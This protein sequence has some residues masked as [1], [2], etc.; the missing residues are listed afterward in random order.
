MYQND[1][2]KLMVEVKEALDFNP[3]LI[4]NIKGYIDTLEMQKANSQKQYIETLKK[5]EETDYQLQNEKQ[6][7]KNNRTAIEGFSSENKIMRELIGKWA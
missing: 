1:Y 6:A 7:N 5:L 4:D 3:V 2:Q